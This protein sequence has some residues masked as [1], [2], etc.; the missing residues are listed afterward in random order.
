MGQWQDC[1]QFLPRIDRAEL[2]NQVVHLEAKPALCTWAARLEPTRQVTK[3]IINFRQ[4]SSRRWR[5]RA[6]PKS[7]SGNDCRLASLT[8]SYASRFV[9]GRGG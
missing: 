4:N 1:G 5:P 3:R 9:R 8:A 7:H 6:D 2:R